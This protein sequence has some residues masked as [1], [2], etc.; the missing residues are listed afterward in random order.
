MTWKNEY[1]VDV[2]LLDQQHKKLFGLIE[3]LRLNLVE[4]T[5]YRNLDDVVA[6]LGQYAE[7]HFLSEE[8]LMHQSGYPDYAN[9]KLA[10]ES[11]IGRIQQYQREVNHGNSS[12]AE[13]LHAY[14]ISW[15]SNHILGIDRRYCSHFASKGIR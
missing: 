5:Q 7:A 4:R 6:A 9:H 11:M 8:R 2:S 3:E 15:W 13:E 10:H 14:L 1:N 12:V